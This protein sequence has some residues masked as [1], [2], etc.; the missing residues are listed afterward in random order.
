[1]KQ[2]LI[3]AMLISCMVTNLSAQKNYTVDTTYY[4]RFRDQLT[5]KLYLSQKYVH[6]NFP[7][8]ETGVQQL[9]YKANTN[10][11]LGLGFTYRWI[12]VSGS[13]GFS[14]LNKDEDKGRTR[15]LDLQFHLYPLKWAIDI[16]AVFPKGMY[17]D[18]KGY[19]NSSPNA[20][21]YRP[22]LKMSNV[23]VSAYYVR[24]K[25]KFSYKAVT[26]QS[27]W[28]KK[29]A[30]SL[31]Y[32]GEVFVGSLHG[33]SAI[34]PFLLASKYPERDI[35]KISYWRVGPGLGYAHTFVA[36]QHF[37]ISGSMVGNLDLTSVTEESNTSE[38]KISATPSI[39]F[40][41]GLGYNSRD[42][43]ISAIWTG[44]G[45]WLNGKASEEKYY[46][47]A[48]NVRL[49]LAKRFTIKQHHS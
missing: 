29:S 37:F 27:E 48:G 31:L 7:T 6:V 15:G 44:Y 35:N 9:E 20:Y 46:W 22:D 5:T 11:H 19:G 32:G 16:N 39:V 13:Y 42:W 43:N 1:M 26:S 24:N 21:Y 18:P 4:E 40:K 41:A 10:L 17:I 8:Q 12:S 30:G 3:I 47:P 14:F 36:D 38:R 33:D 49:V 34:V 45:L 28:Q 25:E 23:G 2:S